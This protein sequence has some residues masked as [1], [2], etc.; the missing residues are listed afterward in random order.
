[1]ASHDTPPLCVDLD[2]TLL[3]SD[4]LVESTLAMLGHRP[5]LVFALP[6]WALRG[7]AH[8]KRAIARRG[9]VAPEGL[10]YD[11]RVLQALD[12][13]GRE[14][15]HRVLCTASD[16]GLAAPLAA[17]LGCFDEILASDGVTNLGGRAKARALVERFGERGFD[18]AGNA[19]IDLDVWT[20]AR[21]AI[22]V[23]AGAA[24][25]AK[26][27][28]RCEV[29]AHWPSDGGGARTWVKALR[30]HQWLKNL[31]VFV[32]L[33]AAHR[34]LEIEALAAAMAAFVAFGL[35]ASG[36]YLLNDLLDLPV[37][38]QHPRKRLRPFAA[39][40]LPLIQG[41]A[42]A[43]A[44]TLAGLALALWTSPLFAVVLAGYYALT[45]AYSLRLKRVPML[46]VL[47]LAALYTVRIIGGTV[48]IASTLSFW[49]LA[50]SMFIFL[51]LAMLKR[52]TELAA[53]AGDGK[54]SAAGRG[55]TTADLPLVQSLGGAAGYLAV[56][57]LA[58]YINSPESLALYARPEMLWLLCP[59]M[60]FWVSRTWLVA[61]RGGM[62]DD[63]VVFA[64]TDRVSQIIVALCGVVALGALWR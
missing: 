10:P 30:L 25:A 40:R 13:A 2:G 33:L 23:N 44:L 6:L 62:H 32:P 18:Y 35:C 37:D 54:T 43:P 31:L 27:A 45:L 63:P 34:F 11:P 60:L 26:A 9:P 57:V 42:L 49:L 17:H 21:R 1:M 8:L 3:R 22:V 38:R 50:F 47:V 52:Y 29:T 59:L 4:L 16:E 51:S 61:H 24:L 64:V 48:A 7:R 56:L 46:D 12:K 36:V 55:Y 15:R 19:P 41:V 39:G 20:H 28:E 14:G 5:W 58:L 53:M